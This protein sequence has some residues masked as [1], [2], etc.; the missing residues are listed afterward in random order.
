MET[1]KTIKAIPP[2]VNVE[3]KTRRKRKRNMAIL[4]LS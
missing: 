1:I 3:E 4:H 2:A